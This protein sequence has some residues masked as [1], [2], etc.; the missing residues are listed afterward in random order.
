M[1]ATSQGLHVPVVFL[2]EHNSEELLKPFELDR[3]SKKFLTL[4]NRFPLC[5]SFNLRS[6]KL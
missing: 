5:E 6:S 1:R 3:I 4:Q 2:W